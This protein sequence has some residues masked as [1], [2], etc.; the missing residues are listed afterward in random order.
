MSPKIFD[1]LKGFFSPHI[2]KKTPA[3]DIPF[4]INHNFQDND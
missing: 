2:P 1:N 3:N 4:T